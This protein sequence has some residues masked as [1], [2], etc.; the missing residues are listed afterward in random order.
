MSLP[1]CHKKSWVIKDKHIFITHKC[2]YIYWQNI[3]KE[4]KW[5]GFIH[6]R[7]HVCSIFCWPYIWGLGVPTTSWIWMVNSQKL[8]FLTIIMK[9]I[10]IFWSDTLKC[11]SFAQL[12]YSTKFSRPAWQRLHINETFEILAKNC[13]K[14]IVIMIFSKVNTPSGHKG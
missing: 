8:R 13:S 14:Y 1:L 3:A 5:F 9:F 6:W 4:L 10:L 2:I 7:H 12:P 11:S